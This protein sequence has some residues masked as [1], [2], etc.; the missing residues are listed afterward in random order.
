METVTP[1]EQIHD[2]D[3]ATQLS[4]YQ[5]TWF[6]SQVVSGVSQE[7][8]PWMLAQGWNVGG[9]II[10]KTVWPWVTTYSMNRVSMQTW[11]VLY[12]LID[13]FTKAYNEGREAN[14]VR[15]DD[16][17]AILNDT[18]AKTQTDFVANETE[19]DGYVTL[20]LA[21][22]D[23]LSEDYDTF[24]ASVQ[25]DFA[26]LDL[27]G[28]ADEAIINE[29]FDNRLA[30]A[31][32]ELVSSGLYSSV[33]YTSMANRIER[34]RSLILTDHSETLQRL[35]VDV[36]AKKN[37]IYSDVLRARMGI[38]QA[39][40]GLTEKKQE[41]IRFHVDDRNKLVVALAG[42]MERRTDSYPDMNSIAQLAVGLGEAAVVTP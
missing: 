39:N 34:E 36:A 40:L 5:S 31:K 19:Y 35:R 37:A 14:D 22:L 12:K 27:T 16:I 26:D 30:N 29:R 17:L 8:L 20:H 15:Y 25:A 1:S 32:Q 21:T 33:L 13:E 18:I 3:P 6:L 2:I 42:F 4:P 38:I 41:L 9:T 10:D 24:Y 23:E 11:N 28:D 7:S